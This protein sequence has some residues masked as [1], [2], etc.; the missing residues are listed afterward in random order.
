MATATSNPKVCGGTL[1]SRTGTS[2]VGLHSRQ[3]ETQLLTMRGEI[4]WSHHSFLDEPVH[5]HK[6]EVG[7]K[8]SISP[9]NS[10]IFSPINSFLPSPKNGL[11]Q[12]DINPPRQLPGFMVKTHTHTNIQACTESSRHNTHVKN[13]CFTFQGWER[14]R[15]KIEGEN[16]MWGMGP[17]RLSY[18]GNPCLRP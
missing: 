7:R 13:S 11:T 15:W 3:R 17:D 18:P 4:N 2:A 16:E 9:A 12:D 5:A 8:Y 1:R 10:S 6:A 14:V